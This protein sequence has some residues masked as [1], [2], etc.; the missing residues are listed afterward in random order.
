MAYSIMEPK[1]I[2]LE[3]A[4]QEVEQLKNLLA[5][6]PLW[7]RQAMAISL[8]YDSQAA[9]KV[10]HNSMYNGKKRHIPIRHSAMK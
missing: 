1:F 8:H 2:G 6:M 9:I 4:G 5:D 3:L 7:K 10:A